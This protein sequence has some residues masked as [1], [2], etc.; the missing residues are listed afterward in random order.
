VDDFRL[1]GDARVSGVRWWGLVDGTRSSGLDNLRGFTLRILKPAADGAPGDVVCARSYALAET[2]PRATG[3]SGSGIDEASAAREFVHEVSVDAG[4]T[5]GG[6]HT[7]FLEIT[8]RLVDPRG[9]NW[10]WQDGETRDGVSYSYSYRK[11]RWLRVEDTD[12]AFVLSGQARPR[13]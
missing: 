6:G 1:G 4:P 2:A 11:Q 3:R 10:Q 5:L 7:Y 13:P 12:S 9:D 8:A